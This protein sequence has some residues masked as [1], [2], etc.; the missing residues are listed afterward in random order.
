MQRRLCQHT[1][2]YIDTGQGVLFPSPFNSPPCGM[3]DVKS[4]TRFLLVCWFHFASFLA[5]F[6]GLH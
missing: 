6:N 4:G 1:R 3:N 2:D 5:S